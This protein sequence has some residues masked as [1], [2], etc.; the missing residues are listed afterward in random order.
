[1]ALTSQTVL[2]QSKDS[3]LGSLNLRLCDTEPIPNVTSEHQVLVRVLAVALNPT[4]HK[5]LV[6]LPIPN[7]GAG[8]DFCGVITSTFDEGRCDNSGQPKEPG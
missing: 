1:M 3:T 8:C 5:M 4:D 7:N 6:N 2:L